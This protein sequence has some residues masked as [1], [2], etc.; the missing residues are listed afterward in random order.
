MKIVTAGGLRIDYLITH[1]NRVH[2]GLPG[3]NALYSA[4]GAALWAENVHLW[5]R[6]GQNYPIHLL[7]NLDSSNIKTRD[8]I[9]VPGNQDHRTFYAYSANGIRDDTNPNKHFHQIGVPLPEELSNYEHSTPMQDK[10]GDYE[11]LALR[12]ADWPETLS[13]AVAVHLSPL[14]LS[15]HLN[16]PPHLRSVG[17]KLISVDPGERYMVPECIPYI[18][19]I[20]PNVDAFLPSDMEVRSL[21][22]AN[23][24]LW[25]AADTLSQWGARIVVIKIGKDGV[26]VLDKD[27]GYRVHLRPYHQPDDPRINDVTG[28]GDAF[29]GGLI[30]GLSSSGK[31]D[32]AAKMGLASASFI[33]EGYGALYALNT[34]KRT[35]QKRLEYLYNH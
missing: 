26:L 31:L 10:P 2:L 20:L 3:G 22:G 30:A 17:V 19:Q 32:Q 24:D 13:D 18:R 16:V 27:T 6:Y 9:E 8:L 28:A 25:Q 14:P 34:D 5:A 7:Q 33:I 23:C 35:I 29:C 21:F 11:P 4:V 15:T 1:D 12:P